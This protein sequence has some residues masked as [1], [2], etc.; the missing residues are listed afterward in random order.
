MSNIL[1]SFS[2][3]QHN[4][5]VGQEKTFFNLEPVVLANM[6]SLP[7]RDLTH[8]MYS[9]AVRNAGNPELHAAFE[10]RLAK[11]AS[12]LDYPSMFNAM[13]YMLFRENANQSI[14]H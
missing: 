12:S 11:I 8:L 2:H 9:Y 14:W 3:G 13:Y 5:M 1:R 10:A 7:A 6:D 4:Q